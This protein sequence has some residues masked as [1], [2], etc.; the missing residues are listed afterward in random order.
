[1][2]PNIISTPATPNEPARCSRD[3]RQAVV[4]DAARNR[5]RLDGRVHLY[6]D[7][8]TEAV[9]VLERALDDAE[10]SPALLVQTL[11]V[12]AFGQRMISKFDESLVSARMA[13]TYA[14][15]LG[16]P[17]LISRALAMSVQ[18]NFMYGHGVDESRDA[19][20]AEIGDPNMDVLVG[21][22][23]D[24]RGV[25]AGLDGPWTR[26]TP[27]CRRCTAMHRAR[28]RERFHG[29]REL[30][31]VDRDLA[32][33]LCRGRAAGRRSQGAAEQGGGS[34][35][36][37]LSMRAMVPLTPAK[38]TIRAPTPGP[39]WMSRD[40]T[41]VAASCRVAGHDAGLSRGFARELR[42]GPRSLQPMQRTFEAIPAR[43]S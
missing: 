12:L 40:S 36:I 6:D 13:V 34:L 26:P 32:R 2:Q 11:I 15:Q 8:W 5:A 25:D 1:M 24:D 38:K 29:R 31:H 22:A 9:A 10:D 18:L 21:S 7:N 41:C 42:R 33:K 43:R 20:G 37:A 27:E 30:R 3:H 35:A 19:A 39:C 17:A 14:E 16:D 28:R 4:W 23:P